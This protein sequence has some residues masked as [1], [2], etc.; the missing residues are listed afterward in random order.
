MAHREVH[1]RCRESLEATYLHGLLLHALACAR[2][3]APAAALGATTDG[4]LCLVALRLLSA[5][6]SWNFSRGERRPAGGL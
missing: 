2:E 5:I 1:E 4:E 3:A 6:L